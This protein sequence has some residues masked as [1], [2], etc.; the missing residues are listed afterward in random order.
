M[1]TETE[2][3]SSKASK[4]NYKPCKCT[5]RTRGPDGGKHEYIRLLCLYILFAAADDN[6]S[7]NSR[8]IDQWKHI[9]IT[10]RARRCIVNID[11]LNKKKVITFTSINAVILKISNHEYLQNG[12]YN[13]SNN[14]AETYLE[15]VASYSFA[16]T[17]GDVTRP[18]V[19]CTSS[20]TN[21]AHRT[22]Q[23]NWSVQSSSVASPVVRRP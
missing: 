1:S 17:C 18:A 5:R 19:C 16:R 2:R 23:L 20:L 13:G 3:H 22:T 6:P 9:F 7:L 15:T 4:A 21:N 10:L 11:L 14:A 12:K 8:R